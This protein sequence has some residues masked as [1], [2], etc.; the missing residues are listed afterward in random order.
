MESTQT[1]GTILK[2][3]ESSKRILISKML[4]HYIDYYYAYI[5]SIL[6]VFLINTDK[7]FEL[8]DLY[9]EFF[10]E[11]NIIFTDKS[12]RLFTFETLIFAERFKNGMKLENTYSF[13]DNISLLLPFKKINKILSVKLD[14]KEQL[15]LLDSL[16]FKR[17]LYNGGN[18]FEDSNAE[19][20]VEEFFSNIKT[21][22]HINISPTQKME[23]N[24]RL[25]ISSLIQRIKHHAANNQDF[26][27]D[28]KSAYPYSFELST[29]IIPII[30]KYYNIKIDESELSYIAIHLSLFLNEA[31]DKIK[32]LLICANGLSESQLIE[33]KINSRFKESIEIVESC[34]LYLVDKI[35]EKNESIQLIL[36]TLPFVSSIKGVKI[37]QINSNFTPLDVYNCEKVILNLQTETSK[38]NAL[39][40]C[41]NYHFFNIY[42]SKDAS[43]VLDEMIENLYLHKIILDKQQFLESIKRR[44]SF[45]PTVYDNIWIPH[46]LEAI[47]TK[48]IFSVSLIKNSSNIN[49]IILCAVKDGDTIKYKD[50][51]NH[52]TNLL[53]NEKLNLE[54]SKINNF[55]EFLEFFRSV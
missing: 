24:F 17:I 42:E 50:I 22:Y 54:I 4:Y 49:L 7:F 44:E 1:K 27:K 53:S 31:N 45:F 25:H 34:P 35:L 10:D 14:E 28:I 43:V 11:N 18:Y 47:A 46:P 6:S 48:T 32:T 13:N 39:Y 36:T 21:Y 26:I 23:E 38:L 33:L 16:S 2:G 55:S 52:I 20:V 29:S 40:D 30:W 3:L 19:I 12:I 51:F 15:Y 9:T 41:F 37:L 8:Y 5:K